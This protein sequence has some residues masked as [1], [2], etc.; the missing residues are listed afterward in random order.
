MSISTLTY[1]QQFKYVQLKQAAERLTTQE[2]KELLIE[3]L[4]QLQVKSNLFASLCE[5]KCLSLKSFELTL[6]Q[7]LKLSIAK[8]T[9]HGE[10]KLA[11]K[12][13]LL[14]TMQLLMSLDNDIKKAMLGTISY[15]M[16]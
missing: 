5:S 10:T 13:K 9:L 1:E 2:L 8:E 12:D 3:A 4:K 15:Q 11:V 7:S 16:S 6:E 14:E